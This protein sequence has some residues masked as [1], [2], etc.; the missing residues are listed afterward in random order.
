MNYW[1]NEAILLR[2]MKQSQKYTQLY[3]YGVSKTC[4]GQIG[5]AYR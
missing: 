2:K 3:I 5:A 1:R 4:G